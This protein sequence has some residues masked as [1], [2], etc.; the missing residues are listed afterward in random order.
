MSQ[1]GKAKRHHYVPRCYLKN[2][3][4]GGHVFTLDYP[5]LKSGKKE[6]PKMKHPNAICIDDQYYSIL[7]EHRNSN[8]RLGQYDE[9]F[10]ESKVLH[11]MENRYHKIFRD[12]TREKCLI[13]TDAIYLCNFLVQMKTRNPYWA[14]KVIDRHK[15]SWIEKGVDQI[16]AEKGPF[17]KHFNRL[18]PELRQMIIDQVKAEQ[19]ANETFTK[20]MQ[21]FGLIQRGDAASKENEKFRKAIIDCSWILL[22][23]PDGGPKFI[24]SDNPGF[25][26]TIRGEVI[27]SYFGNDSAFYL[28]ISPFCCLLI[29]GFV[30]DR[31]YTD[32]HQHKEITEFEIGVERIYE[33]NSHTTKRI[34]SLL[35]ASDTAYLDS[36][37]LLN[38]P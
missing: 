20:E 31:A 24:T 18:A 22:T 4:E 10:I 14:K 9:L 13:M 16:I 15:E 34:N 27:N 33:I 1:S 29:D 3:L 5:S 6:R 23:T 7:P 32:Q 12:L 30:K 19:H 35:I 8:F 21:F 28:P 37:C 38:K 11:E 2:F 26:K 17:N 25:A 36:V